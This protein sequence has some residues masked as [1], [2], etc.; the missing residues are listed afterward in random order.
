MRAMLHLGFCDAGRELFFIE[1]RIP[2]ETVSGGCR[3]INSLPRLA[4]IN[5]AVEHQQ[6][7]LEFVGAVAHKS[8]H[9]RVKLP[10]QYCSTFAWSI[11]AEWG[12][13]IIK[14]SEYSSRGVPSKK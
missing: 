1:R 9:A 11:F 3:G 13:K 12:L 6:V 2:F 4:K 5:R 10:P 8:R 14:S 7:R